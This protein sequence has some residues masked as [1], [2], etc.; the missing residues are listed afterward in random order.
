MD[1]GIKIFPED[2]EYAK[3]ISKYCD[4]FEVMA[5]PKSNFRALKQL[6][7][8]I[9]IHTIHSHWG[10]NPADPV[11][12]EFNMMA[13]DTAAKAADILGADVIVV[14]PGQIESKKCSLRHAV[15]F[16]SKLDSRFIVENMPATVHEMNHVGCNSDELKLL[17]TRP[18]R[19]IC[20]DFPHAA[21]YANS[22]ELEYTSFVKSLIDDFSPSYFHISDTRIQ[23]RVDMHLHLKEGDLK[24]WYFKNIIPH[25]SR[26]LIETAHDFRKQHKDILLLK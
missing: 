1:I 4:F 5:V 23:D 16:I 13:T 25:D 11:K 21:E 17:T 9:T 8:P 2:L 24:L 12:K 19:R 10:F 20:L 22:R 6:G 18:K 7:R 15:S 3:R 26:L 14:H